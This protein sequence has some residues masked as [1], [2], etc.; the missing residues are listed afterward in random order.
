M[1]LVKEILIFLSL[2]ILINSEMATNFSPLPKTP[3]QKRK[4]YTKDGR[5]CA[6]NFVQDGK[7]YGDCTTSESPDGQIKNEE[8]CYVEAPEKGAKQWDYCKPVMD[9][10]KA[11]QK[12]QELYEKFA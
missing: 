11:R 2:L 10:D 6:E 1:K 8:W 7:V 3:T 4:R 5:K 9:W 12:A